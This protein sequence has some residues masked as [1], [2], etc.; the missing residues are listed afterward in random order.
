VIVAEPGATAVTTPVPDTVATLGV[1]DCQV[2]LA[3]TGVPLGPVAVNWTV[4]P[5][6]SVV[7][8][9]RI[10]GE[11]PEGFVGDEEQAVVNTSIPMTARALAHHR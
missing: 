6:V 11:A 10:K 5:G 7:G 1:D 4:R 9:I 3:V 8:P 2:K